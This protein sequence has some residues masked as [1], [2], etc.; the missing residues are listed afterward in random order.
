M[1]EKIVKVKVKDIAQS[2][3]KLRL[4]A[5]TVRGKAVD[6]AL[7]ILMVLNKKGSDIVKKAINSGIANAKEAHNVD[8]ESL[9]ISKIFVD[10]SRTLK[11]G[12]YASRGRSSRIL[13][14]R[15]H[16]NLELKVK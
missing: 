2:P 11:R 13:K 3:Q 10:E 5:D 15:S 6:K 4:V 14:R 8:K 16:L 12:R 7:D 9:I 1:E